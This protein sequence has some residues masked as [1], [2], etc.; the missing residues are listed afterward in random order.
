MAEK[1]AP[2]SRTTQPKGPL[3]WTGQVL[4]YGLFAAAI[5]VFSHWPPYHPLAPGEALIKVSF[6]HTGKPVGDCRRLTEEELA[7]LPPNMRTP[8]VCPRERSPVAVQVVLDGR[9]VLDR[10]A[11]PSGLHKDGASAMYVRMT[12]PAGEQKLAVRVSDDVRAQGP[13]YERE[14]SVN[15]VPGQILVIDLDPNQGGITMQ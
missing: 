9:T 14:A 8:T 11:L 13:T 7:R 2:S 6:I 3:A 10:T 12:V 4:L 15:L 1:T 5:G